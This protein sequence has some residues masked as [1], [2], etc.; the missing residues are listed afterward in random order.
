[1]LLGAGENNRVVQNQSMKNTVLGDPFEIG[2][3]NSHFTDNLNSIIG[4][5]I[6]DMILDED[7]DVDDLHLIDMKCG[8]CMSIIFKPCTTNCGHTFCNTCIMIIINKQDG[9]IK[10]CPMCNTYITELQFN[11]YVQETIAARSYKCSECN[12]IHGIYEDCPNHIDII[13]CI[14]CMKSINKSK[15]LQHLERKCQTMHIVICNQCD[16][17]GFNVHINTHQSLWCSMKKRV[18]RSHVSM[19]EC[20]YCNDILP[21]RYIESHRENCKMSVVTCKLCKILYVGKFYKEHK[22]EC[23]KEVRKN[24]LH[25]ERRS[26]Q[27]YYKLRLSRNDFIFKDDDSGKHVYWPANKKPIRKTTG[28]YFNR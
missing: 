26:T 2:N 10:K 4:I 23:D 25:E 21:L 11:D 27:P 16:M 5:D 15:M 18:L 8:I 22:S 14:H 24:I 3:I 28:C 6:D 1:M 12:K 20:E 17:R 19:I 13:K 9:I 7:E